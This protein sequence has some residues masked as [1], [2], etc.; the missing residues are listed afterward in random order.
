MGSKAKKVLGLMVAVAVAVAAPVEALAAS[1]DIADGD[2]TINAE[3]ENQTVQQGSEDAVVDNDPTITGSSGKNTIDIETG[4][5]GSANVTIEDLDI[6]TGSDAAIDVKGSGKAD[7]TIKGE[8]N[9]LLADSYNGAIHVN[10]ADLTLKGD[11]ILNI[12]SN[13][14]YNDDAV[15]GTEEDED[16][17]GSINITE[18][19]KITVDGGG[20][21]DQGAAIGTGEGGNIDENA[22]INIGGNSVVRV[23]SNNDGA[24]I[25]TGK[26]GQLRGT[27]KIHENA[28]VVAISDDD[29]AGIGTGRDDDSSSD[30][31]ETGKI[32]ITD[33]AK[34]VGLS[35]DDGA[36]IG[37]GDNHSDM[38][39]QILIDG[40]ADVY[41]EGND[42]SAGI[43][44]G[45]YGDIEKSGLI[46][47]GGNARVHAVGEDEGAGI[48]AGNDNDMYGTIRIKD[49]AHVIAWAGY[50]AAAIGADDHGECEGTIEILDESVVET[51]VA[52]DETR[53][54]IPGEIGY[55][56]GSSSK[57]TSGNE[58]TFVFGANAKI[59]GVYGKDV[60]AL[61][62][63]VNYDI[64]EEGKPVR[65]TVVYPP[66][67][68][69]KESIEYQV[70][71]LDGRKAEYDSEYKG[72]TLTIK[73]KVKEAKLVID[74]ESLD[75]LLDKGIE[76]VRFVTAENEVTFDIFELME[77][78]N[79]REFVI[80]LF[81]NS[82]KF[83]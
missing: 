65:V 77:K 10:D 36:G 14:Q 81:E 13:I 34:V 39:G 21:S 3:E 74:R 55:I 45:E 2:I 51:A 59:N 30:I 38:Y 70:L 72:D 23:K 78:D 48:G 66:A 33:N 76:K 58:T 17:T 63:F 1:W 57:H 64:D 41:A 31:T 44:A 82:V 6:I 42:D 52:D 29:G 12:D 4:E 8:N 11:G 60:E 54:P 50:S 68:E 5:N 20:T 53:E 67:A 69:D 62:E 46:S 61:G 37:T 47:I 71:Y 26:D 9:V 56:G 80:V 83:N 79:A 19:A 28:D 43:G 49:K 15:I 40:N 25:G 75:L 32:I 18:S 27:I 7:I 16:L 24:G 73:T 22:S 35:E